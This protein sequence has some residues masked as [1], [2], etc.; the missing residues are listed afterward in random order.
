[1]HVW[2]GNNSSSIRAWTTHARP[3]RLCPIPC[4]P[5]GASP[6]DPPILGSLRMNIFWLQYIYIDS[7]IL[8]RTFHDKDANCANSTEPK[9]Q[10]PIVMEPISTTWI[11]Q[12]GSLMI[13]DTPFLPPEVHMLWRESLSEVRQALGSHIPHILAVIDTWHVCWTT[14][15]KGTLMSVP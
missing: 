6:H 11:V 10:F 2:I 8:S 14:Q 7:E 12:F 3:I 4:P 15:V 13:H 5:G 9:Q 1:M